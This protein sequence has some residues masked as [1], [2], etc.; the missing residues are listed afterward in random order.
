MQCFK[1][2]RYEIGQHSAKWEE[3]YR[4]PCWWVSIA[5]V[6]IRQ[7]NNFPYPSLSPPPSPSLSPSFPLFPSL[8]HTPFLSPLL[9]R[10]HGGKGRN[11]AEYVMSTVII[12]PLA[13]RLRQCDEAYLMSVWTVCVSVCVCVCVWLWE[14]RASRLAP[15]THTHTLFMYTT[16]HH[17]RVRRLGL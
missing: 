17:A 13:P 5:R 7:V 11:R 10:C 1:V 12:S 3:S 8:A 14:E 2:T 9:L 15:H 16:H 6:S 4:K